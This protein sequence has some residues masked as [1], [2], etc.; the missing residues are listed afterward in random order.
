MAIEKD[1][2]R[3]YEWSDGIG[4]S[5][6]TGFAMMRNVDIHEPSGVLKIAP[7]PTKISST[8]VT[9]LITWLTA[10]PDIATD[11]YG[12]GYL[13]SKV[14]KVASDGTVTSVSGVSSNRKPGGM[15]WKGYLIVASQDINSERI[16]LDA[17]DLSSTWT[18]DFANTGN[19]SVRTSNIE[20][21]MFAHPS[22]SDSLYIGADGNLA[23]LTEDTTFDPT[24][25]ATYT[26]SASALDLPPG[27]SVESLT[28]AAS[29][30]LIGA[31]IIGGSYFQHNNFNGQVFPWDRTSSSFGIPTSL[32]AGGVRQLRNINNTIYYANGERGKYYI[33]NTSTFNELPE[34]APF[35]MLGIDT[36]GTFFDGASEVV[37]GE[38]MVGISSDDTNFTPA[39]VYGF[40]NGAWRFLEISTGEVGEN[41][42][43]NIGAIIKRPDSDGT[44]LVAWQDDENSA[45]GIDEFGQNGYRYTGYK[46]YVE[47]PLYRVGTARQKKSYSY[48]EI[49]LAKELASGQ[50]VRIKY[51][52]NLSDDFTTIATIDYDTY[53]AISEYE[54]EAKIMDVTTCQIRIELTTGS[55]STTTPE[56]L[57]VIFS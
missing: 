2:L 25:G 29:N 52:E 8:T 31:S 32:D 41:D 45:Y 40:R 13:D 27:Y 44:F 19:N 22:E 24:S 54:F 3:I 4:Q 34:L 26:F 48:G 57:E 15:I 17:F 28:Q 6:Y 14:Y 16:E 50:G 51:R 55:N 10:D 53:G 20:A 42:E 39:G 37:Q 11:I 49:V 12:G 36:V 38:Y 33:T 47:S 21:P 46:A 1:T 9:D 7:A 56:L 18:N 43:L 35:S 23:K 30:L 5:P